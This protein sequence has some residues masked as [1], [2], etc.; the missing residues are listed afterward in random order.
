MG[1]DQQEY[2]D[3]CHQHGIRRSQAKSRQWWCNDQPLLRQLRCQRLP[4][5]SGEDPPNQ[6]NRCTYRVACEQGRGLREPEYL[7]RRNRRWW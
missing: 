7:W 4:K 1:M 3:H 6:S 2:R 5:L